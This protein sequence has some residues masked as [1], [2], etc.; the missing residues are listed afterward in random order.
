MKQNDLS[1]Y[2]GFTE[3]L[4]RV[5]TR[6]KTN[7]KTIEKNVAYIKELQAKGFVP[8]LQKDKL[9]FYATSFPKDVDKLSF[10]LDNTVS[11][12][13]NDCS[14][15]KETTKKDRVY[16]A[17]GN[18]NQIGIY[19]RGF[20]VIDVDAI[21]DTEKKEFVPA[22][23][24]NFKQVAELAFN[25]E[26]FP[27]SSGKKLHIFCKQS[28]FADS[29]KSITLVVA[30]QKGEFEAV[31][32][33]IKKQN[34]VMIIDEKKLGELE[35]P[36]KYLFFVDILT[37][38]EKFD[39]FVALSPESKTFIENNTPECIIASNTLHFTTAVDNRQRLLS[40]ST[41]S[42]ETKSTITNIDECF[43]QL[44][45]KV[46]ECG[47]VV[48]FFKELNLQYPLNFSNT[49]ELYV[50]ILYPTTLSH[51]AN[52][53][54]ATVECLKNRFHR[55]IIKNYDDNKTTKYFNSFSGLSPNVDVKTLVAIFKASGVNVRFLEQ[56]PKECDVEPVELVDALLESEKRINARQKREEQVSKNI[57]EYL[58]T[59]TPKFMNDFNAVYNICSKD[60]MLLDDYLVNV[61]KLSVISSIVMVACQ[62]SYE[63]QVDIDKRNGNFRYLGFTYGYSSSGK[64]NTLTVQEEVLKFLNRGC[65]H[66]LLNLNIIKSAPTSVRAFSDVVVSGYP[67]QMSTVCITDEAHSTAF[68]RY[69]HSEKRDV[70]EEKLANHVMAGFNNG[71]MGGQNSRDCKLH[72]MENMSFSF[73]GCLT[74][75][76]FNPIR[77]ANSGFY[78][79]FIYTHP[80]LFKYYYI[81][82]KPV[83][84][85]DLPIDADRPNL[86]A[87]DKFTRAGKFFDIKPLYEKLAE[88]LTP[89]SL[90][91]YAPKQYAR[92]GFT[93]L[94]GDVP[95]TWKQTLYT[96][97][98]EN[99][100]V[101]DKGNKPKNK[102]ELFNKSFILNGTAKIENFFLNNSDI[103]IDLPKDVSPSFK[104]RLSVTLPFDLKEVEDYL[105]NLTTVDEG[106]QKSLEK[107][108]TIYHKLP[109]LVNDL[110]IC[111]QLL[112]AS[113]NN[114]YTTLAPQNEHGE[115]ICPPKED[116]E[117][118]LN[119]LNS[120]IEKVTINYEILQNVSKGSANPVENKKIIDDKINSTI[121]RYI[122]ERV[123]TAT[124]RKNVEFTINIESLISYIKR[125]VVETSSYRREYIYNHIESLCSIDYKKTQ[126]SIAI[127]IEKDQHLFDKKILQVKELAK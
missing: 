4:E 59:Y 25:G 62:N 81:G 85:D 54:G 12:V 27:S 65:S 66:S 96:K 67:L 35:K 69:I 14:W 34:N 13:A 18:I 51:F 71:S 56:T 106:V 121:N 60:K 117:L 68:W 7:K 22:T 63:V 89:L 52:D 93:G 74:Y 86:M 126:W 30:E 91:K 45:K 29:K 36:P 17:E 95:I 41:E 49:R 15:I 47:D 33:F 3:M 5:E 38:T 119:I 97:F 118:Y 122:K 20:T 77:C 114:N 94:S 46:N 102:L 99:L 24:T 44:A 110:Y 98:C 84:F 39:A 125:N 21:Y 82:Q 116:R 104:A 113:E 105:K 8:M 31:P 37:S 1:Q 57:I 109:R 55:L 61:E 48:K 72:T 43:E 11:I 76:N 101:D 73:Y 10:L 16:L 88:H 6:K 127:K 100:P 53:H 108:H 40:S 9:P 23:F 64:T 123:K 79:R 2:V 50:N 19:P 26:F 78:E 112:R 28:T 120:Y 80:F 115:A 75:Q 70:E 92:G 103:S 42:K 58:E 83:S 124:R 111:L 90:G 32:D 107:Y 87:S